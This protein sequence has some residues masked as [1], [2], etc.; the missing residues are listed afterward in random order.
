MGGT[1]VE[2]SLGVVVRALVFVEDEEGEG[3]AEGD[4]VFGAGLDLD[5]VGFV[6]LKRGRLNEVKVG[7]GDGKVIWW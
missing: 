6:A 4:A 5:L 3:G 7:G 1:R 2:V